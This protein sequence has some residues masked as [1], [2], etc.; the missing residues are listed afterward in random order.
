MKNQLILLPLVLVLMKI[1]SGYSPPPYNSVNLT[2][3]T[4]YTP[5]SYSSVNLTLQAGNEIS[6]CTNITSSGTY[7]LTQDIINSGTSKCI[8][9][10]ANN[11]ILDCQGHTIDGDDVADYGIYIYRD[12]EQ[13]TNITIKN[14]IVSDWDTA[15]IYIYQAHGNNITNVTSNSSTRGIYLHLSDSNTISDCTV[16]SNSYGF[17]IFYSGFNTISDSIAQENSVD[18]YIFTTSDS[19]CNNNIENL[20]GSNN[21]PIKY[22]NS[23]V[24]LQN[25]MLSELILCN[26][27]YSN[28]ENVTINASQSKKNNM[29]YLLRT[30][31]TNLTDVIS[32]NNYYGIYLRYSDSNTL[33]NCTTN[34]NIYGIYIPYSDSNTFSNCIIN[35]NS[36]GFY[37]IHSNLNT[38]SDCTANSNS[39]HGMRIYGNSDYNT[40]AN[41]TISGNINAGLYLDED[42]SYDPEN[43]TIYNNLF[44]NS[45]N[46]K[47]DDGIAGENY[48]NTT[49]Q[50]G[51]RIYSNGN[52]IGGNYYTNSTGNGYSDTCADS[53]HDGFCDNPLNL[54]YGTSVAWDYLPL[55]DE[56][57]VVE[58]YYYAVSNI[59]REYLRRRM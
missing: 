21:L 44:N 56:Y 11:V 4:L 6:E 3:E 16:D 48:F 40:I 51:T 13:T 32:S 18:F 58:E 47:I 14:C 41:S 55:S 52:Y 38:I 29:L 50:L 45:V 59:F 2:L 1:C 8:N 43:N 49:K 9:I 23:S 15:N 10:Q 19:D 31:H 34:S 37:L 53:D 39:G 54:S 17:Y 20:T 36:Y 22:F 12:S 42:G 57:S 33:S 35:S 27:D 30:D 7:Y 28:I 24:T 25:E 26:A 46:V 5:P